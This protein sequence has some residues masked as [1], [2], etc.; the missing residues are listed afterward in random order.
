MAFGY[1]LPQQQ[2]FNHFIKDQIKYSINHDRKWRNEHKWT[3]EALG[4]CLFGSFFAVGKA[5]YRSELAPEV[6]MSGQTVTIGAINQVARTTMICLTPRRW[7]R[8]IPF[9]YAGHRNKTTRTSTPLCMYIYIYPLITGTAPPRSDTAFAE[10]SPYFLR[11]RHGRHLIFRHEGWTGCRRLCSNS[12]TPLFAGLCRL[13]GLLGHDIL[14]VAAS[15]GISALYRPLLFLAESN[16]TSLCRIGSLAYCQLLNFAMAFFLNGARFS[17]NAMAPSASTALG[18]GQSQKDQL[19]KR[20]VSW[21]EQMPG[22]GTAVIRGVLEDLGWLT[23]PVISRIFCKSVTRNR[24][25]WHFIIFS[26]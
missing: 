23:K 7:G 13:W 12:S 21:L 3:V 8:T 20:W 17:K 24:L 19:L 26:H 6:T 25:S 18:P 9:A 11:H 4:S 2:Q 5:L 14:W 10:H 22:I 1:W 16:T 15:L